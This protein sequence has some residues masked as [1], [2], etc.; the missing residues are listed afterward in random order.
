MPTALRQNNHTCEVPIENMWEV[1]AA[2]ALGFTVVMQLLGWIC[3][4]ENSEDIPKWHYW[5]ALLLSLPATVFIYGVMPQLLKR[6]LNHLVVS[7]AILLM[8]W[9][10]R[11][12]FYLIGIVSSPIFLALGIFCGTQVR[13]ERQSKWPNETYIR[14]FA[15]NGLGAIASGALIL[16][17]GII[18]SIT[19]L[20]R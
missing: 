4:V 17:V 1:L 19:K 9:V 7:L 3:G 8:I 10:L 16:L 2:L 15:S 18:G 6:M 13:A 14:C 11:H 5:V 12:Q 20:A